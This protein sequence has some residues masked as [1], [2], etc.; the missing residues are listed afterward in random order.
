MIHIQTESVKRD[1]PYSLNNT[2]WAYLPY[3]PTCLLSA[4]ID[5]TVRIFVLTEVFLGETCY[6]NKY[7]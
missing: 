3:L 6:C 7:F 2:F 5:Q 4:L 1:L